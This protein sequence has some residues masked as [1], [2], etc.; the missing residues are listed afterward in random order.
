[1]G[2]GD[3]D[4]EID[5]EDSEFD[6]DVRVGKRVL[7]ADADVALAVK[8]REGVCSTGLKRRNDKIA[9]SPAMSALG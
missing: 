9:S 6:S 8:R 2:A 3:G 1:M 7:A 5:G 4:R